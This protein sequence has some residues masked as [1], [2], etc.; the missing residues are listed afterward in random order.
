MLLVFPGWGQVANYDRGTLPE[1]L[2]L[3]LGADDLLV[4]GE[5]YLPEYPKAKGDPYYPAAEWTEG[6]V[7]VKGK[8]FS[9]VSLKYNLPLDRL[10][11]QTRLQ[12]G[13]SRQIIL[14]ETLVDSFQIQDQ[15]FVRVAIGDSATPENAYFEQLYKGTVSLLIQHE[16][17]FVAT[18]STISPFGSYS[19]PRSKSY[20]LAEGQLIPVSGKRDFLNFFAS[21]KDQ[22]KQ[23]LRQNRISYPR[24][25]YPQLHQLM[26]YCNALP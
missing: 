4:N 18:Y 10:L 2:A 19:T 11:L 24:A 12:N 26:H 5:V 22:I 13:Q 17:H 14:L 7:Y 3:R 8:V 16:K 1:A 25:T 21:K 9:G 23:Y 20:L 15:T 6:A